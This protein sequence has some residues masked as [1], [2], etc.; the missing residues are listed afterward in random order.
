MKN[1][2]F[3]NN[4]IELFYTYLKGTKSVKMTNINDYSTKKNS[5]IRS[6][7]DFRK[8]QRIFQYFNRIVLE[9]AQNDEI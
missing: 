7:I 5:Y 9:L 3:F 2:F 1:I 4:F 8:K 6:L